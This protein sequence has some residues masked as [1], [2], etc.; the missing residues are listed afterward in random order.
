M[1]L[2]KK[3]FKPTWV[4]NNEI[5][6]DKNF[7]KIID[8]YLF[9]TPAK[10]TSS[11]EIDMD[12][13]GWNKNKQVQ[14][15]LFY[16]LLYTTN[17]VKDK[18][19]ISVSN[20][21]ELG[22][23]LNKIGLDKDFYNKIDETRIC[24]I[25]DDRDVMNILYYIRCAI[26]HGRF[27]VLNNKNKKMYIMENIKKHNGN[28]CVKA[29]FVIDES[30]LLKWQD[31]INAGSDAMYNDIN[32]IEQKIK[33]SVI[34]YIKNKTASN[35]NSILDFMNKTNLYHKNKSILEEMKNNDIVYDK[36][37]KKWVTI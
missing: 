18:N 7:V 29:R 13:L 22:K 28:L 33:N 27:V 9:K 25:K 21:S 8:F 20:S 5:K 11:R 23:C 16:Y 31:V 15:D 24:Y 17:L 4:C 6:Y 37:K 14:K 36:S 19:V 1:H 2:A 10:E 35:Q 32:I 3:D 30:I 26:A 12:K 34:K